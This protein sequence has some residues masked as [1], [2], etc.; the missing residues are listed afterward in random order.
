MFEV[1]KKTWKRPQWHCSSILIVNFEIYVTPF[2][3]FSIVD[4]EQIN[5]SGA[6]YHYFVRK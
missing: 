2:S 3:S 5:V 4:F 6:A 1:N